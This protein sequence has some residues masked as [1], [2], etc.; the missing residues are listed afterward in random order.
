MMKKAFAS[1]HQKFLGMFLK[2]KLVIHQFMHSYPVSNEKEAYSSIVT[3]SEG[4]I[5]YCGF[6]E[7]RRN[8]YKLSSRAVNYFG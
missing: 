4:E 2:R 7:V 3:C 1:L 5:A 8:T 6:G